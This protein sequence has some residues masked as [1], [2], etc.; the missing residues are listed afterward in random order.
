MSYTQTHNTDSASALS[1]H[2]HT[3]HIH[4]PFSITDEL[5]PAHDKSPP[6]CGISVVAH[7]GARPD[8]TASALSPTTWGSAWMTD[9]LTDGG[10]LPRKK[11]KK[12]CVIDHQGS[13]E[14]LRG[15]SMPRTAGSKR[16]HL[17]WVCPPD[18]LGEDSPA[19]GSVWSSPL[20][21][22]FMKSSTDCIQAT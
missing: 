17:S 11:K 8:P 2:V 20:Q 5:Q 10:I 14:H 12:A 13:P 9:W 19:H 6:V 18:S 22:G 16:M 3:F 1:L 21:H 7:V 4:T 15:D